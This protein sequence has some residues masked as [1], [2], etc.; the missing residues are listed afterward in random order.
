MINYI[1]GDAT[2]PIIKPTIIAHCCNDI[3]KWGSGFVVPLGN[4]YPLAKEIY[5]MMNNRTL[6][7]VDFITAYKDTHN[8]I[9]ANII[10]QHGISN[11]S[12]LPTNNPPIRYEAIRQGFDTIIN[13]I[14]PRGIKTIHMPRIGCGL[15]GGRWF[16]IE[17]ILNQ[18]TETQFYVYDLPE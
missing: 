2:E 5:L 13:W 7:A 11:Y 17:K 8:I 4:K 3:G 15:A 10:G 12:M 1:I 14:Y 18:Y 9:I 6:G 16:E